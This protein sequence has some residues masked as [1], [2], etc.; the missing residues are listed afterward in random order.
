MRIAIPT[1]NGLL[2]PH[3][4]HCDQFAFADVDIERRAVRSM[5][6]LAAPEHQPGLLPEWL[7]GHG[8]TLVIAGGIG[9]R[10]REILA[11][12]GVEVFAG[13]PEAPPLE[14]VNSYLDG[15]LEQGENA[16]DH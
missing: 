1:T 14:V 16:C 6:L 15:S 4:G 7:I 5:N 8:V 12:S 2:C 9:A 10:A 3:F 13:A 11:R